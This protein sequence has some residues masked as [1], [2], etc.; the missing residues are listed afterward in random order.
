MAHTGCGDLRCARVSGAYTWV[1]THAG[2]QTHRHCC[3]TAHK[4]A[5]PASSMMRVAQGAPEWQTT[6]PLQLRTPSA[7]AH[8]GS[9]G[10]QQLHCCAFQATGVHTAQHSIW[11]TQQGDEP[12]DCC[13]FWWRW[14]LSTKLR[15]NQLQATSIHSS[16]GQSNSAGCT[17]SQISRAVQCLG[18]AHRGW[19]AAPQGARRCQ[20]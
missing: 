7:A 13:T 6:V 8:D 12:L 18:S 3:S 20:G 10:L 1:S 19:Q 9:G 5:R 4:L 2:Q 17:M 11:H 15:Q 14:L 16:P